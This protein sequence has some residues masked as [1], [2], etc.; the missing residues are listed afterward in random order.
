M[1]GA[2]LEGLFE[3]RGGP[4]VALIAAVTETSQNPV[5]LGVG[6]ERAQGRATPEA[7]CIT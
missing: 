4:R 7:A 1:V 6:R 2:D 5:E 3:T